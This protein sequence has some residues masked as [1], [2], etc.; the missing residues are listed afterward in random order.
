MRRP[1]LDPDCAR[2]AALCCVALPFDASA[3]FA[4]GK[5]AGAPCRHLDGTRCTIHDELPGRGFGGCV[6]FDCYGAGP[7]ATAAFPAGP[8]R[9]DAFRALREVH[10]LLYLLTEAAKLCP[11]AAL[12]DELA[13]EVAALDALPAS[14][15]VSADRP[16]ADALLRRVGAA[17]GGKRPLAVVS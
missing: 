8:S 6:A 3:A 4:Y 15:T 2:C 9:D 16:R 17:L 13:A 10:E 14:R 11:D 12:R 5:D 1:D 7:R